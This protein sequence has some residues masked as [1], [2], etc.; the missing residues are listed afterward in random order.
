[1]FKQDGLTEKELSLGQALLQVKQDAWTNEG[2]WFSFSF[3]FFQSEKHKPSRQV[4]CLEHPPETWKSKDRII[5][6]NEGYLFILGKLIATGA[7][8]AQNKPQSAVGVRCGKAGINPQSMQGAVWSL[9][10]TSLCW[11]TSAVLVWFGFVSFV[12]AE[13]RP[14][15]FKLCRKQISVSGIEIAGKLQQL[16]QLC[17][18][19][20]KAHRA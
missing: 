5:S 2:K 12:D 6:P 9:N 1:M 8:S 19:P 13:L 4:G 11:G 20:Q 18:L 15:M 10:S 14:L 16:Q 3:T 7:V 17:S